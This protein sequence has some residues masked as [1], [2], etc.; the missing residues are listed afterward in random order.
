[1]ALPLLIT[2]NGILFQTKV[3]DWPDPLHF[4]I[5]SGAAATYFD[6]ETAKRLGM[7]PS[8]EGNVQGAGEGAVKASRMCA[9]SCR[10]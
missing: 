2:E 10:V 3:N 5:D 6:I 8:G 1:V 4:T 9:S 7:V